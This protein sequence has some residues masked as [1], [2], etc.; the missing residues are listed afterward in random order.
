MARAQ[1]INAILRGSIAAQTY[2]RN[3]GG[4]YVRER[5]TPLNPQSDA[6]NQV[7]ATLVERAQE[8]KNLTEEQRRRWTVAA[9]QFTAQSRRPHKTQ[10]SAFNYFTSINTRMQ[11]SILRSGGSPHVT[12]DSIPLDC[13]V[14]N[15]DPATE[16]PPRAWDG[17]VVNSVFQ[18]TSYTLHEV[19]GY[20]DPVLLNIGFTLKFDTPISLWPGD[21]IIASPYENVTFL[22]YASKPKLRRDY[23][24]VR[25][26]MQ[27]LLSSNFKVQ[28][29]SAEG[30]TYSNHCLVQHP[31]FYKTLPALGEFVEWTVIAQTSLGSLHR[32]GNY[33]SEIIV[34]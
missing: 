2:S 18:P 21:Q 6:Q 8:W 22:I 29:G 7:R 19:T 28:N 12:L 15:H 10:L 25:T 24:T 20:Y 5:A 13:V 14:Y 1:F 11:M 4:A 3:K 27:L 33:T 31:E 30:T 23:A 9:Q 17:Q 16:D 26:E 34:A 32:V